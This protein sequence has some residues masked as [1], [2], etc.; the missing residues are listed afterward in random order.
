MKPAAL[1]TSLFLLLIAAAHLLRLLLGVPI[2]I[3][4]FTVPMWPSVLAVVG[5]TALTFWLYAEQRADAT[6]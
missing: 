4:E 2:I 1:V 5:P 6:R 3:D